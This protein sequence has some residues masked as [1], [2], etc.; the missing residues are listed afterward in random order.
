MN[1]APESYHDES[2]DESS[3]PK[4]V[5]FDDFEIEH[6]APHAA[7]RGSEG[8]NF[9]KNAVP[10]IKNLSGDLLGGRKK[11][12]FGS[13]AEAASADEHAE[14]IPFDPLAAPY[15][16]DEEQSLIRVRKMPKSPA[17]E[18]REPQAPPPPT[19]TPTPAPIVIEEE[20]ELVMEVTEDEANDDYESA[21]ETE[22]E[23]LLEPDEALLEEEEVVILD[24]DASPESNVSEPRRAETPLDP[25]VRV[26]LD[27]L[28]RFDSRPRRGGEIRDPRKDFV[29]LLSELLD[30][31]RDHTGAQSALFFWVNHKK[32]HLVLECASVDDFAFHHLLSERRYPIEHDAVSKVALRGEPQLMQSIPPQAEYDLIPYYSEQIGIRSFAAMPV[33]FADALVAV[34]AVDSLEEEQFNAETLRLLTEYSGLISGLVRSYIESYD[35]LTSARTLESARRLY[36]LAGAD[37][38]GRPPREAAKTG[39]YILRALSEA[40]GELVEWEW[41]STIAFDE[42]QRTWGIQHL[43]AKASEGYIGPRT[44]IDLAE[45]I[46]GKSLQTG[47]SIRID[48]LTRQSTRFSVQEDRDRAAGHSFL[49][50]PIRTANKNYGALAIEHSEAGRF[51][52]VDIETL[53][54]LTRSAAAA[55]EIFS[56]SQIVSDRSL[57]DLLT[58]LLNKR[59]FEVRFGEELARAKE[60]NEA[61][62]LVMFEVDDVAQYTSQF[63]QEDLDT[64]VLSLAKVLGY[65]KQP[66]DVLARVGEFSFAVLLSRMIDEEAY[67]WSEKVRQKIV[68]EV[69]AIGRKSFSV[70]ASIGVVGAR[71]NSTREDLMVCARM[72]LDKAKER[73]G[74]E[75]IVY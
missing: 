60:Y 3:S 70:T 35:L 61:L 47:N 34:L 10:R 73:G 69:I 68:S 62:S 25:S 7:D 21:S 9:L 42:G 37:L 24:D 16:S 55:L 64:I 48:E 40:A 39:E 4:R 8:G 41:F 54:H 6:D 15:F 32:Q 28:R 66:Y 49:V 74:N 20:E 52:D 30:L 5:R 65:L 53:E 31:L 58:G 18:P 45:S 51:T 29:L 46:V 67:L 36:N 23:M 19:P 38:S 71:S 57:T 63:P 44:Q 12:L 14:E 33:L 1:D 59:G 56:L 26:Y 2:S 72:A 17:P 11:K 27:T 43:Q 50:I 13:R 22:E 75:V